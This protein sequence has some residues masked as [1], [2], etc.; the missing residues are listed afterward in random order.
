MSFRQSKL[1]KEK[2]TVQLSSSTWC[3]QTT[4]KGA[5]TECGLQDSVSRLS[6]QGSHLKDLLL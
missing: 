6:E 4:S 3:L 5:T 1:K 2:Q